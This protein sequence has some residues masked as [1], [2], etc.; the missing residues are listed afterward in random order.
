MKSGFNI[1]D[2]YASD[3]ISVRNIKLIINRVYQSAHLK[4][5]INKP[6]GGGGG[7]GGWGVGGGLNIR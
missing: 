7:V 3:I 5:G 2:D 4:Y 6:R 1:K